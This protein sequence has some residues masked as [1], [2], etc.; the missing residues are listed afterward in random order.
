MTIKRKEPWYGS[1]DGIP[2]R[3]AMYEAWVYYGDDDGWEEINSAS[4]GN[5]VSELTKA[6]FDDLFPDLPPLPPVAFKESRE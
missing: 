2:S 3:Y 6:D 1:F 5:A 4:H